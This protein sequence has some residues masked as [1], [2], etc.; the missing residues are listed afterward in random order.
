MVRTANFTEAEFT[1]TSKPVINRLPAA[2]AA[3]AQLT[4]EM[5]QRI[6]DAI[7]KPVT[8]TSG[9][10]CPELNRMVGGVS[11]SDHTLAKSGDIIS[12]AYGT[13]LQLAQF[14]APRVDELGIGQL[15]Y[16]TTRTAQWVHASTRLNLANRVISYIDDKYIQG[17]HAK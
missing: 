13:P 1:A 17:I 11:T 8:I 6:R 14:L 16:E 15:I 12:P 9:Y 5:L 3:N 2:L 4:L 7:G 10:R